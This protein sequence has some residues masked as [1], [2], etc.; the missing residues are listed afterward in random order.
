MSSTKEYCNFALAGWLYNPKL[1]A[2]H[3]IESIEK[4]VPLSTTMKE[5]IANLRGWAKTR[6][7]N[8]SEEI[9]TNDRK[10]M[11]ILLTRPEL[12]L[13]RSFDLVSKE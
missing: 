1:E 12:E 2:A 5:Q 11:S 3:I 8:A 9:V 4:T 13:E 7:K 6:A 10:G